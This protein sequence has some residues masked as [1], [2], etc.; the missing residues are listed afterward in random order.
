MSNH[1]SVAAGINATPATYKI[2]VINLATKT[3]S[4]KNS[5]KVV[6][7]IMNPDFDIWLTARDL[8]RRMQKITESMAERIDR[9]E[10]DDLASLLNE[11]QEICELL[12]KLRARHGIASWVAGNEL[13]DNLPDD[14]GAARREIGEI[15]R[16]LIADDERLRRQLQEKMLAVKQKLRLVRKARQAHRLYKGSAVPG[17]GTFVDSMR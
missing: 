9:G 7:M 16:R 1:C 10:V 3:T 11:R 2:K 17:C 5:L 8:A 6:I 14:A 13:N 4:M 12:D 15:F